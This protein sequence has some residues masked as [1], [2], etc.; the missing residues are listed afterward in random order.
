MPLVRAPSEDAHD[1]LVNLSSC[2]NRFVVSQVQG[3]FANALS[4]NILSTYLVGKWYVVW[5]HQSSRTDARAPLVLLLSR[6]RVVIVLAP[7]SYDP[8]PVL[9]QTHHAQLAVTPAV[10]CLYCH[11]PL[12]G[13]RQGRGGA[14]SCHFIVRW[15]PPPLVLPASRPELLW[16]ACSLLSF[17]ILA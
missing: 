15:A 8:L 17:E 6:A 2:E 4:V 5:R 3:V 11:G 1:T 9:V 10:S 13:N 14:L 16:P 12:S 7:R